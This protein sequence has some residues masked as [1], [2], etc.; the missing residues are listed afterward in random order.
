ME[1]EE[2]LLMAWGGEIPPHPVAYYRR[3]AA[4][5]RRVAEGATTWAVKA[6]LLDEAVR[7]DELAAEDDRAGEEAQRP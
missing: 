5:S 3:Q 4:R 6:R 2:A 1:W 7:Y